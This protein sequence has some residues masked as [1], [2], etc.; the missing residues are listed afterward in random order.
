MKESI[1]FQKL[2]PRDI[3]QIANNVLNKDKST[4]P[5]LFN[6][7]E[8]S[9]SASDKVKLFAQNFSKISNLD[10]SCIFLPAFHSRTYLKLNNVNVTPKLVK[11]IT[12]LDSSKA[13]G[14]DCISVVVLKNCESKLS[15]ILAELFNKKGIF[16][17]KFLQGLICSPCL[18]MPGRGLR[19]NATS[20]LVFF[21]WLVKSF[22]NL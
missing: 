13:S 3:W 4:I 18:K 8:V 6:G 20:L 7:P 21:L 2:G 16:S 12:N 10:D 14:P 9:S 1:T 22:E 17:S 19:L 11:V 15:C 5:P